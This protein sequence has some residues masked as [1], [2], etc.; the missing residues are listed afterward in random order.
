MLGE[1]FC[2]GGGHHSHGGAKGRGVLAL[3]AVVVADGA[4]G[5]LQLGPTCAH[6][7][8]ET[9]TTAVRRE[10]VGNPWGIRGESIREFWGET[11][12]EN[13]GTAVGHPLR[14]FLRGQNHKSGTLPSRWISIAK[15]TTTK[16]E[17]DS[18]CGKCNVNNIFQI[19]ESP[20]E[21]ALKPRQE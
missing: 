4:E 9:L 3:T 17:D 13:R 1:E 2:L 15:D 12:M 6:L 16:Q 5:T 14:A 11:S 8:T 7:E 21:T 18:T 20:D 10:S 19:S